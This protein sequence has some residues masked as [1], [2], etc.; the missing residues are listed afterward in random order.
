MTVKLKQLFRLESLRSPRVVHRAG[1]LVVCPVLDCP[2]DDLEDG[3][4]G[5]VVVDRAPG[6]RGPELQHVG[7]ARGLPGAGA[8]GDAEITLTLESLVK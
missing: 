5:A 6:A 8:D 1:H 2:E 7:D 3:A 4:H